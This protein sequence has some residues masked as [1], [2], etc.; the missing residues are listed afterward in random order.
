MSKHIIFFLFLLF[1][2]QTVL[3]CKLSPS[4]PSCKDGRVYRRQNEVWKIHNG[5]CKCLKRKYFIESEL[6]IICVTN[7]CQLPNGT[8]CD[9]GTMYDRSGKTCIC[10]PGEGVVKK[11][12]DIDISY[13]V[14]WDCDLK[15]FETIMKFTHNWFWLFSMYFCAAHLLQW[16]RDALLGVK[17]FSLIAYG[18]QCIRGK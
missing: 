7:Q 3:S 1:F 5:H 11:A 12:I 16:S 2:W 18:I 14:H 4:G 13:L 15:T 8:M 9:I 17:L 10:K 6:E